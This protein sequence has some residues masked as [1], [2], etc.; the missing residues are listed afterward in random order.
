M[1]NCFASGCHSMFVDISTLKYRQRM[2]RKKKKVQG[3]LCLRNR[4]HRTQEEDRVLG[5]GDPVGVGSPV[6]VPLPLSLTAASSS[7]FSW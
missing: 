7:S 3:C 4:P 2:E 6:I 5:P 1:G